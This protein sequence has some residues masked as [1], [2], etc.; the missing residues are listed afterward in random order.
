[1]PTRHPTRHPVPQ[2]ARR[3][4]P[5]PRAIDYEALLGNPDA[6][7]WLRHALASALERDPVDVA[8]EAEVVAQVLRR[9]AEAAL[10]TGLAGGPGQAGAGTV[11]GGRAA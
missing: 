8:I 7:L 2:G 11:D 3:P 10:H 1:M 9:R 4:A 6:S 5:G